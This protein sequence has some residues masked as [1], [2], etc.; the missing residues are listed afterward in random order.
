M[1]L[2]AK[3]RRES[4]RSLDPVDRFNYQ[5]LFRRPILFLLHGTL[6]LGGVVVFYVSGTRMQIRDFVNRFLYA[7]A[8]VPGK[9]EL[10]TPVCFIA[11]LNLVCRA[12][13]DDSFGNA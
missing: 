10:A 6:L 1:H 3:P 12:N 4:T 2:H 11:I 5:L 13:E 7:F 9:L 8:E